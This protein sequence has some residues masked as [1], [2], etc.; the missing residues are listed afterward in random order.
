MD[1]RFAKLEAL[2]YGAKESDVILALQGADEA[3]LCDFLAQAVRELDGWR[4]GLLSRTKAM[5]QDWCDTQGRI[6][7]AGVYEDSIREDGFEIEH[8]MADHTYSRKVFVDVRSAAWMKVRDQWCRDYAAF[9]KEF[10]L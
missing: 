8:M 7:L 10:G 9:L 6:A 4:Y 5:V 1:D 2:E 3:Y